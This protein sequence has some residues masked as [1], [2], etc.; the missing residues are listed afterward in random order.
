MKP[1]KGSILKASVHY[2]KYL[3]QLYIFDC[4]KVA[5][6]CHCCSKFTMNSSGTNVHR[7]PVQDLTAAS[8]RAAY[9]PPAEIL[10]HQAWTPLRTRR[11]DRLTKCRRM[12][13]LWKYETP[14]RQLLATT[15][16]QQWRNQHWSWRTCWRDWSVACGCPTL[17]IKQWR[18][19]KQSLPPVIQWCKKTRPWQQQTRV[20]SD[21]V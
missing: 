1:N 2:I 6:A 16:R 14:L 9:I 7:H 20:W 5:V 19:Q 8:R 15:A 10:F 17:E 13:K 11:S 3:Q 18:V 21:I 4:N 12:L